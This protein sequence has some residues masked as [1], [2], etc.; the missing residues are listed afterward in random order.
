MKV[1]VE[2]RD[3]VEKKLVHSYTIPGGTVLAFSC[4]EFSIDANGKASLS[5]SVVGNESNVS[6]IR[7][8]KY[9]SWNF[10]EIMHCDAIF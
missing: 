6:L 1:N 9:L 10:D 4:N 8:I 2:T 7:L 3:S 5:T